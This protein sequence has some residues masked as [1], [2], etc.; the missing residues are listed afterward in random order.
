MPR[1]LQPLQYS[2]LDA[3]CKIESAPASKLHV[4]RSDRKKRVTFRTYRSTGEPNAALAAAPC[5]TLT[6]HNTDEPNATST[7]TLASQAQHWPRHQ[8]AKRSADGPNTTVAVGMESHR[9]TSPTAAA[10]VASHHRKMRGE[11]S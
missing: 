6:D 7:A 1:F 8:R 11:V 4:R 5:A 10:N 9:R 3:T 2:S